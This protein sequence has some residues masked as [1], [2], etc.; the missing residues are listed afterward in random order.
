MCVFFVEKDLQLEASYTFSL[1]CTPWVLLPMCLLHN[2]FYSSLSRARARA[3]SPFL[4]LS[5]SFIGGDKSRWCACPPVCQS[6]FLC[7]CM[8]MAFSHALSLSFSVAL[9]LALSPTHPPPRRRDAAPLLSGNKS[10]RPY[11]AR[12]SWTCAG[13]RPRTHWGRDRAWSR[14][15]S[16]NVTAQIKERNGN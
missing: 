4:S 15:E 10:T 12:T 1:P 3:L 8:C 11:I 14:F 5:L 7:A 13:C 2:E 6:V 16:G 9:S